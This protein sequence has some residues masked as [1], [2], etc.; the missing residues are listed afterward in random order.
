MIP[1]NQYTVRWN[2][3]NIDRDFDIF[4]VKKDRE[5]YDSN[6]LDLQNSEVRALAVQYTFGN[7]CLVLFRKNEMTAARLSIAIS[8][9]YEDVTVSKDSASTPAASSSSVYWKVSTT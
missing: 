3:E 2:F 6:V 8:A 5:M 7:K 1:T 9:E 4:V